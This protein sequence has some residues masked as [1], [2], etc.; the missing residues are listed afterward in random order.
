MPRKKKVTLSL[1][2]KQLGLSVYTVSKALRGLPGMS[3]ETRK[4]VLQLAHQLGY[5]TKDQENSLIYEGIP[6]LS[7]K[8]RRF[9]VITSSDISSSPSIQLLF[10]GLKERMFELGHK[11]DLAFMPDSL[12]A[13]SFP[14]WM[15]LEGLP[16]ADGLFIT[17]LIP[18]PLEALLLELKMPKI[19]LNFPPVGAKVDSVIWDVHD[20]TRQSVHYLTKNGHRDLLYFGDV[21][22]TRGYKQRWLAFVEAMKQEGLPVREEDHL[23]HM[24][25][26]QVEWV[27]TFK[28]HMERMKPT[29]LLCATEMSLAWIYYALSETGYQVPQDVSLIR[30]DHVHSSFIPGITHPVLLMKETGYRAADRMLWRLANAHLPYEHIRLQGPFFEGDTVKKLI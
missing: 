12:P 21:D 3:E 10:Q 19:L 27:D 25:D 30:L 13:Q 6:R 11:I 9:L 15:E 14:S 17:A 2:A 29:A 18:R 24:P 22:R 4:E 1:L 8:Q 28:R 26:N 7:V 5:L 16:Y 20:A 23:I